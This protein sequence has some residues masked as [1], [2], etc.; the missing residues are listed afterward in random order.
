MCIGKEG[1]GTGF[2]YATAVAGAIIR[3]WAPIAKTLASG[4][5]LTGAMIESTGEVGPRDGGVGYVRTVGGERLSKNVVFYKLTLLPWVPY[6]SAFEAS[7]CL[8]S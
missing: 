4:I 1:G 7:K 5:M 3:S 2:T 6:P 8:K